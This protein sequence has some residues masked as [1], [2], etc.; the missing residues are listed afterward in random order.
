MNLGRIKLIF[1][2][3]VLIFPLFLVFAQ[4][5][6]EEEKKQLEKELEKLNQ[7]IKRLDTDINKTKEQERTLKSKLNS[8]KNRINEIDLQI[9]KSNLMIRDLNLQ[10]QDTEKSIKET[11]LS[12][13]ERKKKLANVLKTIYIE[14]RKPLLETLIKEE[15]LSGF[16]D[17]LLSLEVLNIR[18]HELL[19][20]ITKLKLDLE[21]QNNYLNEEQDTLRKA[22]NVKQ[23][24]RQESEEIKK[25]QERLLKMNEAQY[26]K[27]LKEKKELEKRV[28]E[29]NSRITKLTLPG[30]EVPR[31]KKGLFDLAE[32]AGKAAGGVRPALILGLLEVESALGV[33]VGQCNCAGQNVCKKPHLTY[34]QVMSP[35]QWSA[36]EAIVKELGLNINSTPVSCYVNG[37]IVQMGGAMGPAQFMPNTW[38]NLGYKQKVEEITGSKPANPWLAQDAFLAAALYLAN[39]NATN[40]NRNTEIGAV[41]AYL[42]GTT[43]M[44]TACIK[45]G[46]KEYG[47]SV[48]QKA[49]QWQGWI[50][51]GF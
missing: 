48:M 47:K 42:C 3:I 29:I 50:N 36:F 28:A 8:L 18:N 14:D 13:E 21:K 23:L 7:E 2:F 17:N 16:F 6:P 27:Y 1:L 4:L 15:S 34:K 32:W 46:G 11:S 43:K 12:I 25:E 26:Q 38:L 33:N 30:L 51:S 22:L 35:K 37:G 31:D 5:T 49:D 19:E 39:F 9:K 20:E 44:T 24:Q 45:A 41:T 10:I 40:Q